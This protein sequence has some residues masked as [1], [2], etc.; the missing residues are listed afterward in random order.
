MKQ[1]GL[2]LCFI[3]FTLQGY[4]QLSFKQTKRENRDKLYRNIIKNTINGGLSKPL[5][6]STE[7]YWQD[8]FWAMQIIQYHSPWAYNK[9]RDA[10]LDFN[11][12]S[13]DF[14]RSLLELSYSMY[15]DKFESEINQ[16]LLNQDTDTLI[17]SMALSYLIKNRNTD[18]SFLRTQL[19]KKIKDHPDS[20]LL[21]LDLS[22]FFSSPVFAGADLMKIIFSDEFLPGNNIMVSIQ[23]HNR[24]Y[25]GLV[26]FRYRNGEIL[27]DSTG[28]IISY[29][30]LARS[31]T[32]MPWFIRNGN[33]P[34][35]IYKMSGFDVSRSIFI[36]PTPNLQMRMPYEIIPSDFLQNQHEDTVWTIDKYASLL[37]PIMSG[38]SPLYQS[39]Y[40]GQLGRTEIIAHGTTVDPELYRSAPYYP[41]TPTQGCLTTKEIWNEQTGIISASDQRNMVNALLK[42]GGSSGYVVVI[43][44][45]DQ[46]KPVTIDDIQSLIAH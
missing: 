8:A 19:I 20:K 2:V 15:P 35:G 9:V 17:F 45:D 7:E 13:A 4:S 33:T 42:S 38:Y 10:F 11:N 14:K 12:R 36:G 39:F 27:T 44:I 34:Q 46:R 41:L 28:Q 37:P 31:I 30:Q 29:P 16:I 21:D 5:N 1:I 32:N 23:R 22:E 24:D 40:A 6:D 25:P 26:I 18:S 3:A 43:E